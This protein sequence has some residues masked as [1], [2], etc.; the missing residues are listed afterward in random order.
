VSRN[1]FSPIR[2]LA[3]RNCCKKE[4]IMEF[5]SPQ[6]ELG[7]EQSLE[8]PPTYVGGSLAHERVYPYL[9]SP[10]GK[11]AFP[12]RADL[13]GQQF[14]Q[15]VVLREAVAQMLAESFGCCGAD[16]G[17]TVLRPSAHGFDVLVHSVLAGQP[18]A[19]RGVAG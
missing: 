5:M 9:L 15:G 4:L 3:C 14:C 8:H 18:V 10:I 16:G 12:V 1:R 7:G 17:S 2:R 6:R 11:L 19:L 13:S